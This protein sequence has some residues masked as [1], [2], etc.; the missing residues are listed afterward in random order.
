V[1]G[2]PEEWRRIP[3]TSL[4]KDRQTLED[5]TRIVEQAIREDIGRGDITSDT[6]F[7]GD[8]AGEA[9]VMS[10]ERGVVAG[11][12]IFLMV[13]EKIS[14]SVECS[15]VVEDGQEV[16]LGQEL[17]HLRG[18]VP[19]LLGGERTALNFLQRL[20]GIATRTRRLIDRITGHD[21][22]LLDTRKTTPGLRVL[23]KYAVRM[24]GGSNH[25]LNLSGM[26][27]VKEN[28]IAAAGGITATLDRITAERVEGMEIEV[29]V[30]NLDE[31]EDV[32]RYEVDRV[33]LDN[34]S[35]TDVRRAIRRL[36]QID[37]PQARPKVEVSGGIREDN[38]E[39]YCLEGVDFIS[40]GAL[41]HSVRSLDISMIVREKQGE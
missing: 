18:P 37:V 41:T 6:L 26:Y 17:V 30:R 24:G 21:I 32:L 33:M 27:L 38:I 29:E 22:T 12:P 35:P 3:L 14:P 36:E 1:A 25:R 7:T 2:I 28:H 34:F 4:W 8:S 16:E 20:S 11:I 15:T 19:F 23:E 13:Y 31:L 5:V 39:R 10:R 40:V 9:V